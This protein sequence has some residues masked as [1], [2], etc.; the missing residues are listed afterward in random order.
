MKKNTTKYSR[1]WQ[2]PVQL[3]CLAFLFVL[4]FLP[5][6][7]AELRTPSA[8]PTTLED[9]RG[10]LPSTPNPE[11]E[12]DRAREQAEQRAQEQASRLLQSGQSNVPRSLQGA[13]GQDAA[14]SADNYAEDRARERVQN[15][16]A[17]RGLPLVAGS[18]DVASLLN[19]SAV[20]PATLAGFANYMQGAYSD[21]YAKA[22]MASAMSGWVLGVQVPADCS[23]GNDN[24]K[25]LCSALDTLDQKI[26][27]ADDALNAVLNKVTRLESQ[28]ANKAVFLN[29][30]SRIPICAALINPGPGAGYTSVSIAPATQP[31]NSS[32]RLVSSETIKRMFQSAS[33]NAAG[34]TSVQR[35]TDPLL[36]ALSRS[37]A[38]ASTHASGVTNW[39]GAYDDIYFRAIDN[40]D[41]SLQER[42]DLLE[43]RTTELRDATANLKRVTDALRIRPPT[44]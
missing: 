30:L 22:A 9:A 17:S 36:S 39:Q 42:W 13:L 1:V 12:L 31:Y 15:D 26:K 32:E 44:P 40:M 25:D 35:S 2:L 19:N 29:T 37:D 8:V 27:E 3:S 41:R 7:N 43:T 23:G 5:Q 11:A 10:S 33:R 20:D 16:L 38:G 21:H 4:L 18:G 28:L 24:G 14:P 6:V 34:S